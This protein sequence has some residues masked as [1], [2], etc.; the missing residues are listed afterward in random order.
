MN[1][2]TTA[3]LQTHAFEPFVDPD[4]AAEH[5]QGSRRWL[6]QMTRTG[7]IPGHALDPD[8]KKKDW[9]YKLSELDQWI[10]RPVN[11][12]PQPPEPSR[13]RRK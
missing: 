4:T 13:K 11:S 3:L 10:C 9:R 1:S 6:L 2:Q 7:K 12:Q 5:L 8:S